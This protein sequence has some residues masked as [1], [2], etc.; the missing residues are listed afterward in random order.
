MTRAAT[1]SL[2]ER[3]RGMMVRYL[4][5]LGVVFT[6]L[7][8]SP[9]G[10]AR[11]Q[12]QAPIV[13]VDLAMGLTPP[14]VNFVRRAL[15]EASASDAAALVVTLRSG[16]GVLG[17]SWALAR[18]LAA[19]D[20]P[21]VVW[22][23]PGPVQGGPAGT[24]LLAASDV[25]AMAPGATVGFARP[26]TATPGGFSD[27]TRQLVLDD[28]A[29]ELAGWQRAH[30]RN[31]DWIQRA[32]RAGAVI[33]AERARSL[34][35]PV[36]DLVAAT[37]EELQTSLVGRR[38]AGEEDETHV[39]DTLGAPRIVIRPTVLEWL[40][41]ALAIPTVAFILFVLG[42]AAI[43]LEIASPG[44]SIPGVAGGA[45]VIAALYGFAQAGVRPLAVV[46]LAAGL[47]VIGLEHVVMSHGGL[48]LGGIILLVLGALWLVDPARSPGLA[49]EPLAIGGTAAFLA[50]AVVGLVAL[51]VRVRSRSPATGK[52]SLIGQVAEV[53]RTVDPEGMVYVAGALWMAWTDGGPLHQGE[54]VEVAGID[55]L[56]LYVRRL[57]AEA[58]SVNV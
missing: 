54:L 10:T 44:V 21:V 35:P 17:A 25:V 39:L 11:A 48:T 3:N 28:V 1:R 16:G 23:G 42:A 33:D 47:I 31:A 37:P 29:Q 50:L 20:V 52:E 27:A 7:T 32:V 38:I 13:Q 30:G 36:I 41:Q 55:N 18:E 5:W 26:L 53:R 14:A 2:L 34:D 12:V 49:V 43:Y 8:A 15:R 56:R 9:D 6:L 46:L 24:L 22:V 58:N 19:A 40:A 57:E 45:L 51:A 4:I